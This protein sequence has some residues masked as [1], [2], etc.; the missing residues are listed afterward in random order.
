MSVVVSVLVL[1]TDVTVVVIISPFS[2]VFCKVEEQEAASAGL[3]KDDNAAEG[4]NS[5]SSE[6]DYEARLKVAMAAA[7]EE[8]GGEQNDGAVDIAAKIPK[9]LYRRYTTKRRSLKHIEK[10]ILRDEDLDFKRIKKRNFS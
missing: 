2:F 9:K 3:T 5:N 1:V 10:T 8:G 7:L 6:V 4:G